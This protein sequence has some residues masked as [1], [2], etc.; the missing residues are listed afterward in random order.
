MSSVRTSCLPPKPPPT[1][2]AT[3]R[4]WSSGRPK[5]RQ[6]VRRTRNGHLAGRADLEPAVVVDR[7]DGG[8]GLQRRVLHPLGAVGLLVDE[9]RRGEAAATSAQFGVQLG[10]DVLLRPADACRGGV[11]VAVDRGA[12]GRMASCGVNT[13]SST[14]YS[15][16][17]AR[18]PA[19]AAATVRRRR[20][21][22]A[23]RRTAPRR[24]APGCRPG[25]R[26]RA[27]A[28]PWRTAAPGASSWVKTATTPG[29]RRAPRL[30]D[31]QHPGVGVRRAQELQVQQPGQLLRRDV[32]GVAGL[33]R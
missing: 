12:P 28:G 6:S 14:W 2:P 16:L 19:S 3:T 9:V 29:I 22:P 5:T 15:T 27:R 13:A 26:C 7:G 8:V 32:Q 17:S 20:R 21:R 4:I 30:V 31:G 24:P 1:R 10:H 33:R 25:R 18:T 11:L 23:A